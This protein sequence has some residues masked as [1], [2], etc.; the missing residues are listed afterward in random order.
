MLLLGLIV[1]SIC[2][3][4]QQPRIP[5]DTNQSCGTPMDRGDAY[6]NNP[7]KTLRVTSLSIDFIDF[8][9]ESVVING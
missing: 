5:D 8:S 4:Q 7:N 6:C 3:T 1:A 9:D 2:L